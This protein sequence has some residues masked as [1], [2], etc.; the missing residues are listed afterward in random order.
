MS[1]LS[2]IGVGV[3]LGLGCWVLGILAGCV[4]TVHGLSD[5]RIC[6]YCVYLRIYIEYWAY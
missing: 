2:H 4:L 1:A 3:R 6:A 5:G